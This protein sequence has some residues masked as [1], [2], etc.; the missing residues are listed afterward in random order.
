[1]ADTS[2][3]RRARGEEDKAA[4]R[5]D[6]LE[7]AGALFEEAGGE[8]PSVD[9]VARRAGL[10]KGT[11][12]LYFRAKEEM[13]LALLTEEL[14]LWMAAIVTMLEDERL[15]AG[16]S[17]GFAARLADDLGRRTNMLRLAQ[18]CHGTLERQ[19]DEEAVLAFKQA[20][21]GGLAELGRLVEERMKGVARGE[22]PMLL[23]QIYALV[24]GLWQLAEPP[25]AARNVLKRPEFQNL[26]PDFDKAVRSGIA[27]LL[28]PALD[29]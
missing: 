14:G 27:A 3:T 9:Q 7:A 5:L 19:V 25:R 28:R 20:T 4:R 1:M 15:I 26:R 18:Q 17:A 21:A 13:F 23:L 29:N 24:I 6:I 11:V 8:L 2:T 16:G 12:Y 10:A 22:G